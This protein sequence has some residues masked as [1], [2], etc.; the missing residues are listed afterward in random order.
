MQELQVIFLIAKTVVLICAFQSSSAEYF[1]NPI[2]LTIG[3]KMEGVRL[4]T[5]FGVSANQCWEECRSRSRC[6]SFDYIRRFHLCELNTR[7]QELIDFEGYVSLA[8]QV[9]SSLEFCQNKY[10]IFFH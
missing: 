7:D 10:S 8:M 4:G 1:F 6:S 5:I 9:C 3:K 2:K